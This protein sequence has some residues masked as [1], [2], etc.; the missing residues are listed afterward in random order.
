MKYLVHILRVITG[1]LFV[2][3]GLVKANDPL[4]LS[5]KMQ[6]FFAAL[7]VGAL[8]PFSL[9][10][11]IA[12][13]TLEV[14]AGVAVLAGYRLRFFGSLILVM[15]L[16]FTFLTG[17]AYFTGKVRECGCF[18]DCIPMSA[19]ASFGKDLV[20][21]AM[22]GVI[23]VRRKSI[24]PIPGKSAVSLVILLGLLLPLGLQWYA[25]NHLPLVDCLP[26]AVGKNI[27]QEMLPPPGAV[28][29]RYTSIMIYEKNGLKKPFTDKNYP[30][31][32][33]SWHFIS[34]ED[35]LVSRGNAIPVIADFA[36][37]DS[38]GHNITGRILGDPRLIF[39]LMVRN[40]QDAGTG[41]SAKIDRLQQYCRKYGIEI[42]GVTA[43]GLGTAGRYALTRHL[44]FPFLQMDATVIKTAA[45]SN[46]CL[47]L[48]SAGTVLGKWH[49][50]DFP[51]RITGLDRKGLDLQY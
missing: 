45:R 44:D 8:S 16:V 18:G 21:L 12:M 34:R 7:H 48:L 23:F 41:W 38:T 28:P 51:D 4:G 42:Y 13:I 14:L 37:F 2:F 49:Y 43:S 29:D 26:Y 50:H 36:L 31:K 1:I 47:M 39:L 35:K 27:S 40:V 33:T 46:P 22:I 3:S 11:S 24:R 10:L 20:L 25:L 6:E 30:W 9:G 5:Y 19:G 32:D 15:I 17:F